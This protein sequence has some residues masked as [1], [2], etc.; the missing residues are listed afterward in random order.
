MISHAQTINALA[1]FICDNETVRAACVSQFGCGLLVIRDAFGAKGLPGVAE[2]P[3][4]FLYRGDETDIGQSDENT[5][6]V[7]LIIGVDGNTDNG[8]A[9]S[10]IEVQRTGTTNGL[11]SNGCIDAAETIRDTIISALRSASVGM[12]LLK[13]TLNE[14]SV[15]DYPL[16]CARAVLHFS[17]PLTMEG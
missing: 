12:P 16:Q 13:V 8:S 3:F 4:C 10:T 6:T 7:Y 17:E 15:A 5:F 14:Y 2:A 11:V 9:P 1:R